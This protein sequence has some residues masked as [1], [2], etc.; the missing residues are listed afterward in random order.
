M[1]AEVLDGV[2]PDLV[3][4]GAGVI[5]KP[6]REGVRANLAVDG[7]LLQAHLL[8]KLLHGEPLNG[9]P[10]PHQDRAVALGNLDRR[11]E[12]RQKGLKRFFRGVR[13][14]LGLGATVG[15]L[16]LGPEVKST[17]G[18]VAPDAPEISGDSAATDSQEGLIR[19]GGAVN[20][21]NVGLG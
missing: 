20:G 13:L 7:V 1:L 8:A 19:S 4:P 14:G 15:R 17:L 5:H 21:W 3:L 16:L 18:G 10:R 6:L 9:L 2:G 12:Q 11:N